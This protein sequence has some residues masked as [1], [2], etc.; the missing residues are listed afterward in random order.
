MNKLDWKRIRNVLRIK[1]IVLGIEACPKALWERKRV[2]NSVT[3]TKKQLII[4][5]KKPTKYGHYFTNKNEVSI[6]SLCLF[7]PTK[8][9][10]SL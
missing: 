4:S 8:H 2:T 10:T 3:F 7:R 5:T 9:I 6:I 1:L